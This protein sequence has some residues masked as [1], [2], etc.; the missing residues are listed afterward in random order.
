MTLSGTGG[1]SVDFGTGGSIFYQSGGQ[2][3]GLLNV[4]D[5]SPTA[6]AVGR[7]GATWAF[8]VDT[9]TSSSVTGLKLTAAAIGGGVTLGVISSGSSEALT[10]NAKGGALNLGASNTT[11]IVTGAATTIGGALTY[12]GTTFANTV[13]GS[14]S[15]VGATSPTLVTPTLGV[16]TA[17][18]I[19]KV[20]ITAPASS[21]TLTIADGKTMTA[22]NTLTFTGTDGSSVAFGTGGTVLYSGGSY[23]SSIAGT[24]NQITAS[25][26][27]GA[28]TLSLPSTLIAPGTL[29]VTGHTTFEGVTSTGATGTG[30]LVYSAAPTFTGTALGDSLFLSSASL[31]PFGIN[32]TA[33]HGPTLNYN[34]NS[35]TLGSIGNWNG[36]IGS[37]LDA[38]FALNAAAK[39]GLAG[40]GVI[41]ITIDAS[42]NTTISGTATLS[43]ALTYGGVTL[44]NSAL[45][46]GSMALGAKGVFTPI[47]SSGASLTFSSATGEYLRIG[48]VVIC[49]FSV[50]YPATANGSNAVIGGLPFTNAGVTPNGGGGTIYYNSGAVAGLTVV[51]AVSATTFNIYLASVQQTNAN[52]SALIL[53]GTLMY[54]I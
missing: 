49:D 43:G 39:L 8:Q 32:S 17:T 24:S 9:N 47:D 25:A 45:G 34:H 5:T 50:T 15:L 41:G 26:S 37:G 4:V 7:S 3:N 38:D 11:S 46:T 22:S 28:V 29:Q 51:G 21:A 44:S 19:N 23:V 33:T 14:G 36:V 6:F 16:A 42:G 27:T 10:I 2:I 54:Y 31:N 20:A 13:T 1:S 48:N 52:L 30:K 35:T 40:G 18:S 12:G 53:R